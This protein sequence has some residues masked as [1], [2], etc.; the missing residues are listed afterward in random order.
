LY[1]DRL[2]KSDWIVKDAPL[3]VA[4]EMVQRLHYSRGGS[5]TRTFSHGLYHVSDPDTCVGVAW[6]IPPTKSAALATYPDDW[7][8]VLAL[9]RMVI[10]P[11]A[12]K[13]ACSFLLSRSVK[14][15]EK[16]GRFAC[17]V[18]YADEW[19]GHVGTIYRASNWLEVGKTKPERTYVDA[20]GRMVSRKA[21][22]KTRTH[23]D[24]LAMGCKMVG[25]FAKTKFVRILR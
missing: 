17:L 3:K 18:T 15:I 6:W 21:G 19:Q 5:N 24:M 2:R 22:P 7:K 1:E 10:E 11:Y 23:A 4:Q 25:A 16:D 13:N 20:T 9:S 12:P 14:L 8:G